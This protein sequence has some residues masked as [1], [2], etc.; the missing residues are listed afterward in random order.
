MSGCAESPS[1]STFK[2]SDLMY[3]WSDYLVV[4]Y[5]ELVGKTTNFIFF[6]SYN[7][8]R[9]WHLSRWIIIYIWKL[10]V[11]H[12]LASVCNVDEFECLLSMM[13][14]TDFRSLPENWGSFK[15]RPGGMD[16]WGRQLCDQWFEHDPF[17]RQAITEHTFEVLPN[18]PQPIRFVNFFAG[19][20]QDV[21]FPG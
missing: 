9:L 5:T 16:L 10:S 4:G 6:N 19:F 21:S 8:F 13:E 14:M 15:M 20:D 3:L 12:V 7:I 2:D 11:K 18:A 17:T 1:V